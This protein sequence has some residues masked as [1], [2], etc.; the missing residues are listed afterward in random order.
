MVCP[1]DP[2][3]AY[4][5]S[6]HSVQLNK[7]WENNRRKKEKENSQLVLSKPIDWSMF[8]CLVLSTIPVNDSLGWKREWRNVFGLQC[9]QWC[10][11]NLETIT[12]KRFPAFGKT[13]RHN[14]RTVPDHFGPHTGTWIVIQKSYLSNSTKSRVAC[15][16]KPASIP[17][18]LKLMTWSP[19]QPLFGSDVPLLHAFSSI[20]RSPNVAS[21]RCTSHGAHCKGQWQ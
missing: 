7:H 9:P 20:T 3:W 12:Q 4:S 16:G 10:F 1:E 11:G 8:T 19:S 15:K 13:W 18:V 5:W 14:L 17:S 6:N 2:L 21:T